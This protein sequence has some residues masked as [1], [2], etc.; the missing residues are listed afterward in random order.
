MPKLESGT[1]HT[2]PGS[3]AADSAQPVGSLPQSGGPLIR[4]F[5]H[6][7]FA[8]AGPGFLVAV[9]YGSR[10][11]DRPGGGR[12]TTSPIVIAFQSHWPPPPGAF[13]KLGIVTGRDLARP[14]GIIT[15][16]SLPFCCGSSATRHRGL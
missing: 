8:F 6:K 4:E 1:L 7:L 16:R 15:A 14:A 13:I 10:V 12:N 2:K 9:G 11:G 5:F 3:F